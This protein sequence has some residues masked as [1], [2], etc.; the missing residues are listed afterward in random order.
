MSSG[1]RQPPPRPESKRTAIVHDWLTGMRGG[2]I[3]GAAS[4][5]WAQAV[6]EDGTFKPIDQLR[7]LYGNRGQWGSHDDYRRL[8]SGPMK[9]LGKTV[10]MVR[11]PSGGHD[12]SR[13]GKPSLRVE[14]LEH[15]ADWID[16]Y[17]KGERDQED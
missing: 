14:R 11:F 16:L 5:P 15:I 1:G 3:P 6:R 9:V 10:K 8:V 2:H 12:V 7:E 4:V 13:S 17:T